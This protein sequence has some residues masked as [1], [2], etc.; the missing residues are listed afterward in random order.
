MYPPDYHHNGFHPLHRHPGDYWREL[1]IYIYITYVYNICIYVYVYV[2][3][4]NSN[5]T[6]KVLIVKKG[7]HKKI[8]SILTTSFK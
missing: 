8:I 3:I 5:K 2:Y 4:Y 6:G 1:Y 7:E